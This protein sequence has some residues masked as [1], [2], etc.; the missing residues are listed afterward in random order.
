MICRMTGNI[1]LRVKD[2][3][4]ARTFYVNVLGLRL[5]GESGG[6][7]ELDAD[8][9]V[10]YLEQ[11]T[12]QPGVIHEFEVDDVEAARREL[13]AEGCEILKW[14]GPGG[15]CFVRDPHG[16]TFNLWPRK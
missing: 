5:K 10:I 3:E 4:K 6:C 8:P 9:W 15:C 12:E 14:E 1:N 2:L 11:D 13:E 7:L 16:L